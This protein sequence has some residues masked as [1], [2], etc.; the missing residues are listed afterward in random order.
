MVVSLCAVVSP[1]RKYE[2]LTPSENR[3]FNT[4]AQSEEL[5][6]VY[7]N[8]L[9][10]GFLG[11]PDPQHGFIK[12]P[13]LIEH[14]Q[15]VEPQDWFNNSDAEQLINFMKTLA[16]NHKNQ[17]SKFGWRLSFAAFLNFW[18]MFEKREA[19]SVSFL[20]DELNWEESLAELFVNTAQTFN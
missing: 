16:K 7:I 8:A 9:N 19:L 17:M 4:L 14:F 11:D 15:I 5:R 2:M 3:T 10:T 12:F 1:F 18:I 20:T 13:K 6:T